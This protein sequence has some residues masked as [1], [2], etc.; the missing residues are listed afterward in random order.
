MKI[1][2]GCVSAASKLIDHISYPYYTHNEAIR[3]SHK[4][5]HKGEVSEQH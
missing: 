4:F 1:Q 5:E 2:K 3:I